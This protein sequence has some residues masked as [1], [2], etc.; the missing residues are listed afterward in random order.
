M[1]IIDAIRQAN[2]SPL[3]EQFA[4]FCEELDD[5]SNPVVL[6]TVA[7]LAHRNTTEGDTCLDLRHYAGQPLLQNAEHQ[8]LVT[9]PVFDD[10]KNQLE[11]VAFTGAPFDYQPLILD[12]SRFYLHRHWR[13]ELTIAKLLEA[14]FVAVEYDKKQLKARLDVLFGELAP[15][16]DAYGQKLAA[17]MA[18]TRKLTII[19]GGPG[20]G[21]TTTVTKILALLLEQQPELRISLAAPTGKAAARRSESIKQQLAD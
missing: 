8:P 7:L 21:K 15:T 5:K 14:R 11:S 19:T 1:S 10:W 12:G 3:A 13:Q 17:A 18:M 9:A 20:T 6:A 4:K 16:A 2:L